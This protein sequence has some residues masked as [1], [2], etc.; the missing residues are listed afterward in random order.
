MKTRR[1]KREEALVRQ[2]NYTPNP[3]NFGIKQKVK[4]GLLMP[5]TALEQLRTSC[6]DYAPICVWLR[7]QGGVRYA[8]A[9]K[10]TEAK[11]SKAE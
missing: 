7:F 6:S 1:Q 11:T 9:L 8:Q 4:A 5:K 3:K 10:A 2:E